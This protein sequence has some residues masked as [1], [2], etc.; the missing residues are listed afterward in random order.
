[1]A[2]KGI[3]RP[4]TLALIFGGYVLVVAIIAW[5][6]ATG[7]G[8]AYVYGADMTRWAF[9]SYMIVAAALLGGIG[10]AAL[11]STRYLDRMIERA[12]TAHDARSR[13]PE[14]APVA[15]HDPESL[16]PPLA[17]A[18]AGSDPVDQDIDDLLVSL[19]EIETGAGDEVEEVVVQE[20]SV[21]AAAVHP[22]PEQMDWRMSQS[23]E[24]WKRRRAEVPSYFA[25]PALL[26]IAILGIS[27]AML[28]GAD[29][30]LQTYNQL[31]TALLLGIGYAYGG[32]AAYEA[33]SVYAVLRKK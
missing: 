31:N 26:S 22:V 5:Y 30:M 9:T 2:R 4:R 27:A 10:A 7:T 1:M 23:L 18:P 8:S 25:G 6:F 24:K 3:L 11:G 33:A 12:E 17:E 21:P 14:Y 16:P 28:P 29:A 32:I 13:A 19:Q 20:T 15:A